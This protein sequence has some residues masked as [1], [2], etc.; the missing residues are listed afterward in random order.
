[1]KQIREYIIYSDTSDKPLKVLKSYEEVAKF[2]NRSMDSVSGSI[3]RLLNGRTNRI[4][5][6]IGRYFRIEFKELNPSKGDNK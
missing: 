2:L 3:S 1:M 5:N 4:R 6:D